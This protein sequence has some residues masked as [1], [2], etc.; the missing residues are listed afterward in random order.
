MP[1]YPEIRTNT[2]VA[3]TQIASSRVR[4]VAEMGEDIISALSGIPNV[5]KFK[6]NI[7]TPNIATIRNSSTL[8]MRCLDSVVWL[9]VSGIYSVAVYVWGGKHIDY[10]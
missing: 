4:S 3:Q 2:F 8:D 9:L 10:Q 6:C 5:P 7:T 1:K